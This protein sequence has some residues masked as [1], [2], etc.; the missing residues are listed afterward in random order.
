MICYLSSMLVRGQE[1]SITPEAINS[2]YWAD[3]VRPSLG[4]TRRLIEKDNQLAWVA[5]KTR[6]AEGVITLATKRG[7]DAPVS[8][9]PKLTSGSSASPPTMP[10]DEASVSHMATKLVSPPKSGLLKVA[11]ITSAHKA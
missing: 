10:S 6:K 8:K 9:R 5:D 11:R 1:V 4:F 3:L 2:I 7:K